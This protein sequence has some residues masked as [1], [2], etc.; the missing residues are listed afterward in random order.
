MDIGEG[1]HIMKNVLL[2]ALDKNIVDAVLTKTDWHIS[3]LIMPDDMRIAPYLGNP[4]I[5]QTYT[6]YD[7]H[8]NKDLSGLDFSEL[9]KF[10]Y[11]QLRSENFFLRF[12]N[13]Y[14]IAKYDYYLGFALATRIFK[15]NH[16]DLVVVDGFNEG[17]PSD[18]LLTEIARNRDIPCY[19][20]EPMFLGKSGIYD[21]LKKQMIS[22]RRNDPIS[23]EGTL[24]YAFSANKLADDVVFHHS[25]LQNPFARRIENIVYSVFGQVGVDFCSCLYTM[26][27]RKNTMGVKF[28]ERF[29]LFLDAR[30]IK[31]WLM[32]HAKTPNLEEKYIFFSLHYEPEATVSG[33]GLIDSQLVALRILSQ[34]LP[35]GWHIYVKEHP[36]QLKYNE[37][38]L[39]GY[40]WATYKT[41][42]FYE[43]IIRLPNVILVDTMEPSKNLIQ[44]SQA[45]ASLSGTAI[46]EAISFKKPIMVFAPKQTL[47]SML[48]ESYNIYSYDECLMAVNS[49]RQNCENGVCPSYDEWESLCQQYLFNMDAQGYEEAISSLVHELATTYTD[50]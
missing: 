22:I 34:V 3:A 4:R 19:S 21:N 1:I 12:I 46:G 20:L 49:I 31:K 42:R 18:M 40:P 35:D 50:H 2:L 24:F 27:N 9:E 10:F 39:Y 13:D 44:R 29:F 14:Q 45:V 32:K 43:E 38:V 15:E 47:Y 41:L 37:R 23:M 33:R 8:K 30:K 6:R 16:I 25:I 28:T 7:F 36:H 5:R 11:A 48:R 17:R 26:S